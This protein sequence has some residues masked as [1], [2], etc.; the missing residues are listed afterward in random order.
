MR[1][2]LL[3]KWQLLLSA[4][5]SVRLCSAALISALLSPK[6]ARLSALAAPNLNLLMDSGS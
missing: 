4:T 2:T 6:V 1:G 3:K 5:G